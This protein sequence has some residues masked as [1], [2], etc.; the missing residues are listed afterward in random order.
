MA[1]SLWAAAIAASSLFTFA[2]AFYLPGTAP[3]DYHVDERVPLYVNALT[4]MVIGADS[5]LVSSTGTSGCAAK[6][7]SLEIYDQLYE[8]YHSNGELTL[9]IPV[10]RRLLQP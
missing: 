10:T 8:V 1:P 7:A 4:P 5:K 2:N 3:R 6:H 9:I